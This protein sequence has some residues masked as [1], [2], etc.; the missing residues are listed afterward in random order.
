LNVF[1]PVET[2]RPV[3]I[4]L[5]NAGKLRWPQFVQVVTDGGLIMEIAGTIEV[6]I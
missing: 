2:S 1:A 4:A 6:M 3:G 5:T